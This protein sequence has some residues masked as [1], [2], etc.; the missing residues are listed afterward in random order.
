MILENNEN[1]NILFIQEPP[2]LIICQI[3]SSMSKEEKNII[4]ALYYSS[5]ITFTRLLINNN[6]YPR[7][8][9]YINVKLI[10]LHFLLRKNIFNHWDIN[11]IV[12]T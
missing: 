11:L 5:W 12:M 1:F 8:N 3:L 4:R 2:W 6:D 10:K 9:I 7:V